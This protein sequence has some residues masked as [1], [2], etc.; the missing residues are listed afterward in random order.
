MSTRDDDDDC[1]NPSSV[2]CSTST[3]VQQV[4]SGAG[5]GSNRLTGRESP[6]ERRRRV[7]GR[8]RVV[9]QYMSGV[10]V[11]T[12]RCASDDDLLHYGDVLPRRRDPASV[13]FEN[14]NAT[15][16]NEEEEEEEEEP[17]EE[18]EKDEIEEEEEETD[19]IEEEKEEDKSSAAVTKC[20][21][22]YDRAYGKNGLVKNALDTW[23]SNVRHIITDIVMYIYYIIIF[24]AN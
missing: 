21:S 9:R 17:E 23:I 16:G 19:E 2:A 5:G 7:F 4:G 8:G 13:L 20:C 18:K 15:N 11:I 12:E 24:T 22:C 14:A 3:A 6:G 10:G 1:D